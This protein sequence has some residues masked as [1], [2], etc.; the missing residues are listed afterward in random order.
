MPEADAVDDAVV[1]DALEDAYR[2]KRD[3]D[4]NALELFAY[5]DLPSGVDAERARAVAGEVLADPPEQNDTP[6]RGNVSTTDEEPVS[7][8]D[9]AVSS[10]TAPSA[11]EKADFATTTDGVYPPEHR[12]YDAWMVRMDG[13]QPYAPWSSRDAPAPCSD[14]NTDRKSVV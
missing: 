8:N 6:R 2:R 14:H 10:E 5:A 1:R 7:P 11:W 4:P 12:S 3:T 13:K 9:T